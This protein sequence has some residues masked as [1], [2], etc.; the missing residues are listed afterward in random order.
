[1]ELPLSFNRESILD[2]PGV[3]AQPEEADC[4]LR[5]SDF[6]SV[7]PTTYLVPDDQSLPQHI[8]FCF[9]VSV[10]SNNECSN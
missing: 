5:A 1:M 9:C 8:T 6:V 2:L 10:T 4:W 3:T 7:P